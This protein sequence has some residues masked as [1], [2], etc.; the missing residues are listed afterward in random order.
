MPLL[1]NRGQSD[2]LTSESSED[3]LPLDKNIPCRR[4]KV[5]Q[6]RTA[7]EKGNSIRICQSRHDDELVMSVCAQ[8]QNATIF[9]AFLHPQAREIF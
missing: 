7:E 5:I 8:I 6:C 2:R 1:L 9:T 4:R 3:R